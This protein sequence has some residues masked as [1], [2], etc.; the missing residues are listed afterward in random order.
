ME[1]GT[2]IRIDVRVNRDWIVDARFKVYGCS[3]AIASASLVA[4][5]LEGAAV[6]Q[7]TALTPDRVVQALALAPE[8]EYVARMAVDAALEAVAKVERT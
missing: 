6:D 5:W 7:A 2:V 8:R 3:A 4:E 1:K